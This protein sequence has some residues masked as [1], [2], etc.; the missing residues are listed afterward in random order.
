MILALLP[1]IALALLL[2]GYTNR[3]DT[4]REGTSDFTSQLYEGAAAV[5]L[6]AWL[7]IPVLMQGG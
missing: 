6:F 5:L 4:Q 1:V 3:N 2:L 7:A